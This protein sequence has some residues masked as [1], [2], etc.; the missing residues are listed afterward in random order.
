M[1]ELE[2]GNVHVHNSTIYTEQKHIYILEASGYVHVIMS[3]VESY[4]GCQLVKETFSQNIN[5]R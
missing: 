2:S 5:V 3:I 4:G 1:S